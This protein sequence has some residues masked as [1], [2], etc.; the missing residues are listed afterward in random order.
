MR[1]HSDLQRQGCFAPLERLMALTPAS[2]C[3]DWPLRA[4][5]QPII[6]IGKH[7]GRVL[8]F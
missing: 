4:A 8:D 6:D 7:F 3:D 2:L 5:T 1:Y